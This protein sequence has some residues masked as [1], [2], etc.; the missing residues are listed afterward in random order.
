MN[1][2]QLAAAGRATVA[3]TCGVSDFVVLGWFA[4][5]W[6]A[7]GVY[8]ALAALAGWWAW[9]TLPSRMMPW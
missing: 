8:V 6:L 1:R 4:G 3:L 5:W 7:V 9:R 2:N